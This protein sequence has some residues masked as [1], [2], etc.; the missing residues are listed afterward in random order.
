MAPPATEVPRQPY[1]VQEEN[2]LA[3]RDK[4][5]DVYDLCYCL[6]EYPDAIGVVA[7][8]WRSRGEDPLVAASIQ[9][10]REKFKA[11]EHYGP[12]QLVT[13]HDSTDDAERALHA[14][15]AFELVQ[16]LL[17]LL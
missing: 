5:K 9:I 4:P 15:R 12:Q 1:Y 16:K 14:R 2:A 17:S 6:D 3:G 11:V 13:F 7:A 8:D 10:L